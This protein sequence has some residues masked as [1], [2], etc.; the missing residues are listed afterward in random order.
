MSRRAALALLLAALAARPAAA[1]DEP[2]AAKSPIETY[3]QEALDYYAQGDFRRAVGKWNEVLKTDATQ[4]TA[5]TMIKEARKKIAVLT[6]KRRERTAQLIGEGRYRSAVLEIQALLDQDP[7]DP[8]VLTLQS[9]LEQIIKLAPRLDPV[10]KPSRVAVMGLQAFL[11][12]PA[13]PKRAHD[14]LRYATELAPTD[15][16]YAGFLKL[17]RAEHPELDENEVTPGMKLLEWKQM[18]AL[19]QIYDA[20]HFQAVATLNDILALEPNDVLALKRLGSAYYSL[21]RKKQ[22]RAAWSRAL[23]LAPD[24]AALKKFLAKT[25][26]TASSEAP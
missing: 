8:Q 1:E 22:A 24:D 25:G 12:T 15:A 3:Y 18:I 19:H 26:G 2:A 9:R 5:Q 6:R 11:S 10:D 20:K 17:L 13:E 21:G 7:G 14:A 16:R 23:R 4:K